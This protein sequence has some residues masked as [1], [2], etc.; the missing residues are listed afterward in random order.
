MLTKNLSLNEAYDY[1][2]KRRKEIS[3]NF[4]PQVQRQV[5][6]Q[7]TEYEG[8]SLQDVIALAT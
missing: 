1:V 4:L 5:N 7:L 3:P 6:D 2:W 8:K